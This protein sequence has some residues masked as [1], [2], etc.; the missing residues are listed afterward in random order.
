MK[1]L[2]VLL[3]QVCLL[4]EE[5]HNDSWLFVWMSLTPLLPLR[6]LPM[7]LNWKAEAS[8]YKLLKMFDFT[9]ENAESKKGKK[10]QHN[11]RSHSLRKQT[12]FCD[13]TSSFPAKWRLKKEY[14]NSIL[15]THHYPDPGRASA[16]LRQIFHKQHNQSEAVPRSGKRRIISI[17]FLCLFLRQCFMGNQLVGTQNIVCFLRLKITMPTIPG[18]GWCSS[19]FSR[20]T[21]SLGN[22]WSIRR[23]WRVHWKDAFTLKLQCNI[24]HE[25]VILTTETGRL[26][27]QR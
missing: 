6:S 10:A 4:L 22:V 12:T 23:F 3:P 19:S 13:A 9:P 8:K 17:E 7:L 26:Q 27:S 25:Y 2:S 1:W 11:R 14:R 18:K 15:M 24:L 16:W 21:L 5:K 20:C